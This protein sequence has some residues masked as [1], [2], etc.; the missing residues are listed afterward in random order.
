MK[1]GNSKFPEV[2]DFLPSGRPHPLNRTAPISVHDPRMMACPCMADQ[3]Q[4]EISFSGVGFSA[5][6]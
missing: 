1:V 6:T 2:T 5:R 4:A 3:S